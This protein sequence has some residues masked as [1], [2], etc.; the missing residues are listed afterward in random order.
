MDETAMLDAITNLNDGVK[1][2][3]KSKDNKMIGTVVAALAIAVVLG[4]FTFWRT[5]EHNSITT[6]S[7]IH[8]I[9]VNDN[10]NVDILNKT[11]KTNLMKHEVD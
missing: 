8:Q 4:I 10:H 6:K 5:T 11:L 3:S 7:E 9:K 1:D 2:L